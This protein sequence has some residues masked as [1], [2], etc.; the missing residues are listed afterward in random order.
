[1]QEAISSG[2][3][4]IVDKPYLV[5]KIVFKVS[6]LPVIKLITALFIHSFFLLILLIMLVAYGF[7]PKLIWIQT[8]YYLFA[9]LV[10]VLGI[11][12][13]T[14]SIIVFVK[15]MSQI[16][17]ILLQFGFW[18]TPIFWSD[19]I[20]PEKYLLYLKINPAYYIIQGYRDSVLYE[21]WFWEKPYHTIYFWSISFLIFMFGAFLFKRL[22][23]HFADVL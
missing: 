16:I 6:T 9:T 5:K 18:L 2:S 1:M 12:W 13:A 21:T 7:Y 11:S 23:P 15:D 22:R 4:S 10:L 20:M 17:S 14:S 3:N 19:K 8:F